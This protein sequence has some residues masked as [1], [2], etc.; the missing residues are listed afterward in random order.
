MFFQNNFLWIYFYSEYEHWANKI[1]Y[2][3]I[4]IWMPCRQV[5]NKSNKQIP[6]RL[7]PSV[8]LNLIQNLLLFRRLRVR[9]A[10]T[11]EKSGTP[12]RAFSANLSPAG[13]SFQKEAINH[14]LTIFTVTNIVSSALQAFCRKSILGSPL[15]KGSVNFALLV[16]FPAYE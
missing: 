14:C 9:P 15:L 4:L 8:I 2:Q 1:C 12:K 5:K 7:A 13:T 10:M 11:R 16:V 6:V 3:M